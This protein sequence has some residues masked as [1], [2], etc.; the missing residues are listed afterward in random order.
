MTE[1]R[2]KL[3][4]S[5]WAVVAL[6]F[7]KVIIIALMAMDA[8]LARELNREIDLILEGVIIFT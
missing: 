5:L 6:I 4:L 3:R 1:V 8:Y 2:S 7:L